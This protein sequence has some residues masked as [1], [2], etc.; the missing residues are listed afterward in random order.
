MARSPGSDPLRRGRAPTM[1]TAST[2]PDRVE[3]GAGRGAGGKA[4]EYLADLR[5]VAADFDNYRKR[6]ARDAEAQAARAG[7]SLVAELL[8]VLDNL[9][10]ALDA[11][12]HHE[13]AKVAEGVQLVR[14]QL[15]DL[16]RRRGLEEIATE[17]GGDFDPHVHEAL[18]QQPSEHPEGAIAA[19]WQ[20]GYRMGDRVVRAGRGGRVQRRQRRGANSRPTTRRWACPRARPPTRSRRPT[21]S[22]PAQY[23]PDANPGDAAAEERFKQI[24]EAYDVLSDPDKR[25]QYD[26]FGAASGPARG[27][28]GFEGFDFA[29]RP[30]EGFDLGDLFGGLFARRRP[31]RPRASRAQ[32][33][34]ADVEVPVRI[35]FEDALH[36]AHRQGA[37]G[38]GQHLQRLPRLR[39]GAG[40]VAHHLPRLQGPRRHR[41]RARAS[42]RSATPAA[43]AA[44]PGTIIEDACASA[45]AAA[46]CA[47]PRPTRC[48]SRPASRTAPASRCAGKGEAAL[49]AASRATCTWSRRS[50]RRRCS[51]AA[52]TTWWSTCR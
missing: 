42:S 13:E 36:G 29:R 26:T 30:A 15:V 19:V 39:R 43:A 3:A 22:W 2:R 47:R 49:A 37:R 41:P 24:N 46:A 4:E 38:Q 40:H 48:G 25:K 44:A 1:T 18:S 20:R 28:R 27:R 12:E 50:T 7:E 23:H 8:P 11:S 31:R 52:A 16:L 10:R 32:M 35:S 45:A 17:P 51:S 14:Q 33:R 21:A 5:R 34:G 9:E 6:V